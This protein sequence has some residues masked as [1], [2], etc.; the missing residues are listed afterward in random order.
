VAFVLGLVGVEVGQ[1][2]LA[3]RDQVALGAEVVL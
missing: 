1:V 2:V 3:Q